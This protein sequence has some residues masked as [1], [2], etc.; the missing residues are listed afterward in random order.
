LIEE[1]I[2]EVVDEQVKKAQKQ[3]SQFPHQSTLTSVSFAPKIHLT[4]NKDYMEF[5]V[6]YI[7]DYRQRGAI[8][9]EF[10][11]HLLERIENNNQQI[12]FPIDAIQILNRETP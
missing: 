6:T 9:H 11:S 8:K 4:I 5:K 3:W 10:F 1:T 7:V 2:K 12:K